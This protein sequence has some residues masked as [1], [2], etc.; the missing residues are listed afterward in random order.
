ME[1]IKKNITLVLGLSIPV[2]MILFVA[3]SIYL[4]GLFIKPHFNFLYM[5]NDN[6]YN[7]QQFSVENGTLVRNIIISKP[8]TATRPSPRLFV[9]DVT[10]NKSREI[11]FEQA[12]QLKINSS[13]QSPDNLNIKP[14]SRGESFLL[15][16]GG[17]GSDYSSRYLVGN[18]LSKKLKIETE[19][20][21]S[22][23]SNNFR[24]L[25]WIIP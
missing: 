4:P 2:V 18:G 22:Y 11:T 14:G 8:S 12:Q 15:F 16:F 13:P 24:L 7:E 9:H 3:G 19:Q 1:I 20:G 17:G 21:S 5:V 23:F 25:G 6:R 10:V